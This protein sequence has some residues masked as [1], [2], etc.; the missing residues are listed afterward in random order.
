LQNDFQQKLG[1]FV[2][3]WRLVGRSTS[4]NSGYRH[5]PKLAGSHPSPGIAVRNVIRVR[6][7]R[8]ELDDGYAI[9]PMGLQELIDLTMELVPEGQR[10]AFTAAQKVDIALKKKQSHLIVTGAA[11]SAALV[12]AAPI[13]FSDAVLLVPI[14]IGML[15]GITATFGLSLNDGLLSSLAGSVI[16]GTG[17]TMAGRA[18]IGGLLKLIPGG[19][20]LVGG[21]LSA[22]TALAIT[23]AF[24]EAYI[25]TLELLF[26]RNNGEPPTPEEL[27]AT[28]KL[29]YAE[30]S[31]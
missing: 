12:G 30:K 6:A 29:Q 25:T 4:T 3:N 20:S 27:L 13:P 5:K 9:G 24:G 8:E 19:G 21:A 18:L 17:A 10:R 11:A 14:Q 7:I 16:T 26:K 22:A 31:K 2:F 1:K 15:A 28:F 23:T